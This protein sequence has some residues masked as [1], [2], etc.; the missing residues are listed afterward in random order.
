[1]A[2]LGTILVVE[3][4]RMIAEVISELLGDEGYT[5]RLAHTGEAALAAMQA[6][7]PDLV[8]LDYH[9]PDMSGMEVAQTARAQGL[10]TMPMVLMSATHPQHIRQEI[11]TFAAYVFKPFDAGELLDCVARC[12]QVDGSGESA[13]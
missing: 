7:R 5:V 2:A 1:M 13:P 3:D 6:E 4:D 9:L 10:E 12:I 11:G 8:I